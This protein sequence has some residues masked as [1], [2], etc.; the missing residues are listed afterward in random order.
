MA[1]MRMPVFLIFSTNLAHFSVEIKATCCFLDST[2]SIVLQF[3]PLMLLKRRKNVAGFIGLVGDANLLLGFG[4]VLVVVVIGVPSRA[5]IEDAVALLEP[6][7]RPYAFVKEEQDEL[8]PMGGT[9]VPTHGPKTGVCLF[10][11]VAEP[12]LLPPDD[13]G[14]KEPTFGTSSDRRDRLVAGST[15]FT[16]SITRL[17]IFVLIVDGRSGDNVPSFLSQ[18]F[19]HSP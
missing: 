15:F 19:P 11:L 13:R 4:V 9:G 16:E 2:S 7:E 3:N 1:A 12:L 10:A 5:A 17:F 6:P 14:G 18:L 8:L